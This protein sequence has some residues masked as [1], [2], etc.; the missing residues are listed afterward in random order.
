MR[1]GGDAGEDWLAGHPGHGDTGCGVVLLR[2][3]VAAADLVLKVRD[4][5]E[6][7]LRGC[8]DGM[9]QG[10]CDATE[11]WGKAECGAGCGNGI[12]GLA[13]GLEAI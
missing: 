4:I 6:T 9:A 1:R 5:V 3:D 7:L 10:I 11:I 8:G 13:L 12:C 2:V